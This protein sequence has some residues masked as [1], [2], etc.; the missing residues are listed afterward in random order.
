MKQ[1]IVEFTKKSLGN[2]HVIHICS[3][4]QL[5]KPDNNTPLKELQIQMLEAGLK[6]LKSYA[7]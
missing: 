7:S 5:A 2:G 3:V 1:T 4:E 6:E